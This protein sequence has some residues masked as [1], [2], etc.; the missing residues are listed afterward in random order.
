MKESDWKLYR[1]NLEPWRERYL[2]KIN[3][4]LAK[5]LQDNSKNATET[6]WDTVDKMEAVQKKLNHSLGDIRR[7]QMSTS[8]R[9][10]LQYNIITKDDLTPF[11]DELQE[12]LSHNY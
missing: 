10:M 9:F 5:K 8:L 6:F 4:Q 2:K 3:A 11:S 12:R 7:S 1:A